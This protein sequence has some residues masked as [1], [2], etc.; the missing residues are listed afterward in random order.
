MATVAVVVTVTVLITF[1]IIFLF[2][3]SPEFP[4]IYSTQNDMAEV[5][6]GSGTT[7]ERVYRILGML[8]NACFLVSD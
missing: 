4:Y 3:K 2:I 6:L 8:I 7:K 5:L 1:G